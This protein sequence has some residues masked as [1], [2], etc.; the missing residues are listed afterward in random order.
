VIAVFYFEDFSDLLWDG[1]SSSSYYFCKE[2]YL[3]LVEFDGHL[4]AHRR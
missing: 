2:G 1:Y 3:F 4:F